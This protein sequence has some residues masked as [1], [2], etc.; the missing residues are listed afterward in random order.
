MPEIH[1][2]AI[3]DAEVELAENVVVGPHCVLSGSVRVGAGSKL[4]GHV[5]LNGPLTLGEGNRVYPFAT[6]G[7]APQDFKWELERPGAARPR[8]GDRHLEC[9]P[10]G[11]G[12]LGLGKVGMPV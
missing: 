2:T 10:G 9:L 11:A 4:V 7:F 1:P 6:L 12:T 8:R 5:Y 3:V